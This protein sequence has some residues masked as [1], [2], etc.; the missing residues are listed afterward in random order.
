MRVPDRCITMAELRDAIDALDEN[1]ISLLVRRADH[2]D[3][4]VTLRT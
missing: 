3:R 1:L 2:I 4:A